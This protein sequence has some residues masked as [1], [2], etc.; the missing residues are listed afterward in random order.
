[1]KKSDRA[2]SG[3][4]GMFK[5]NNTVCVFSPS[6]LVS[7]VTINALFGVRL[8]VLSLGELPSSMCEDRKPET[9]YLRLVA[10]NKR[11]GNVK[12]VGSGTL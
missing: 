5:S 7:L 8:S 11:G 4:P 3:F 9:S 1:M 6:R 10:A 12:R 2:F